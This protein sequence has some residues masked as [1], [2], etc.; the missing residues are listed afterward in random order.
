[1][2]FDVEVVMS[3]LGALEVEG[4]GLRAQHPTSVRFLMMDGR[5]VGHLH[6]PRCSFFLDDVSAPMFA[7]FPEF[8]IHAHAA[9]GLAHPSSTVWVAPNGSIVISVD[10]EGKDVT[11]A[12]ESAAPS[13]E[14]KWSDD[15][16]APGPNGASAPA[17]ALDWIPDSGRDFKFEA[18]ASANGHLGHGIYT[19]R[20]ALPRGTLT[21][22][23]LLLERDGTV[24]SWVFGDHPARAMAEQIVWSRSGVT[25]LRLSGATNQPLQFDGTLF[26]QRNEPPLIRI[27]FNNH[28]AE[29]IVDR[30]GAPSHIHA[31]RFLSNPPKDIPDFDREPPLGGASTPNGACP[32]AIVQRG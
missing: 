8:P 10:L 6:L 2:P 24:R 19:S 12:V 25:S 5:N 13:F 22:R 27:A 17:S 18:V 15:A 9:N 20:I 4:G 28:P 11:L 29:A 21:S 26:E 7:L 1:M 14:A 3:G 23:K 16:Q 32:P 30:Y 31:Y